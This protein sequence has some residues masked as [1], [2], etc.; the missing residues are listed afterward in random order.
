MP[1]IILC[2]C[3]LAGTAPLLWLPQLPSLGLLAAV[4]TAA[5]LLLIAPGKFALRLAL[6]LLFFCWAVLAA[7]QT[8]APLSL[9]AHNQNVTATILQT[10]GATRH[11]ARITHLDGKWLFPAITVDL[12]GSYLAEKVCAG[13]RWDLVVRL[14]AVHGQL[15]DGGFDNQ[16]YALSQRRSVT[17]RIIASQPVDSRC[18]WRAGFMASVTQSLT[19]RPWRDV[20]LAL[21]FGERLAVSDEIKNLMRETGTAHLMA[22]SGLHIGLAGLMGW[23]IARLLQFAFPVRLIN[24]VFPIIASLVASGIYTWLS[25][26]NPPALRTFVAMI[27]WGALRLSGRNGDPWHVWLCCV[28]GIV[29]IDPLTVLSESFWLSVLAVGALLFWYQ[30]VPFTLPKA[31]RMVK[32][33]LALLHLQA[34][35]ALLLLPLQVL[36]FHGISLTSV[37]ANLLAV[38][39]VTFIA[40]PLILLAMTA[41]RMGINGAEYFLEYLADRSLAGVFYGLQALPPGWLDIDERFLGLALSPWL[42]IVLWRLRFQWYTPLLPGIVLLLLSGPLFRQRQ[43]NSWAVHML[44]IGHGLAIVIERNG[45]AMLYDTGNAWPG[46]D[47]ATQTI[48]PWLRWHHLVPE[49]IILSHEHLDH[50]GGLNSLLKAWPLLPV[51]SSLGWAGHQPCLRGKTWR[52]QG[53]VFTVHWPL[54]IGANNGNNASCVVKV[55]DG[56]QSILLTGDIEADAE[57]QMVK[58]HWHELR[59]A[60]LQ[61]PHHGSKTSSSVILLRAVAGQDALAS[62]A[63]YNAWR[64]PSRPVIAR[65]KH[66]DYQWQDTAHAGQITVNFSPKSRFI[67]RFRQQLSPRWYHQWFGVDKDNG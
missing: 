35:M 47:S 49:G 32:P 45:R 44:D 12:P 11:L 13:Q 16:R 41:N 34:G 50:R 3:L 64:L 40:V 43:D 61:V 66:Y 14:K 31:P 63:R 26:A 9:T 59:A 57:R 15:N 21:G 25:G 28:T 23:G 24:H 53:L 42:L 52:W 1:L 62:V 17:G 27:V 22:I 19:S 51:M 56:E 55:S 48:I 30:W 10:D 36:L 54:Q 37:A 38:P 4:G 5:M 67:T 20:M 39:V 46:G 2:W 8:L 58:H 65:Y 18:S 7:R 60:V 6:T 29:F 33:L